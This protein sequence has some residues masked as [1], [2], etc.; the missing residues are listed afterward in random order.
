MAFSLTVFIAQVDSLLSASNDELGQLARYRFIKSAV[1]RYGADR[2]LEVSED[3]TGNGTSFYGY[4]LLSSWVNDF[5]RVV[6]IEYP[7]YAVASNQAP[8]YLGNEDF[9][10]DYRVGS[11]R[12]LY[13][14]NHSP[15]ASDTLRIRYTAPYT[16]SSSAESRTITQA[17]HGFSANDYVYYDGTIWR[18]AVDIR[19]ATHTVSSVADASTFTAVIHQCDVP[20]G[21]FFAVCHL[22]AS[23]CCHAI[24]T[25]YSRT[26]DNTISADSVDHPRREPSF[27]QRAKDFERLYN[28]HMGLLREAETT[29]KAAGDFVDFDVTPNFSRD[30]LFHSRGVR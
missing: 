23:Y 21:D 8:Q 26:S 20:I 4:S 11:T 17:A 29:V 3:E 15:S 10:E 25:K 30:Y 13:L 14:P 18:E 1:E 12:Y 16:W 9:I 6:S 5:S 27:A 22:A 2:P 24:A 19:N 7:A 28:E